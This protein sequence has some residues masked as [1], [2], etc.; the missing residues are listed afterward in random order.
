[1]SIPN[2]LIAA[3]GKHA[4]ISRLYLPGDPLRESP[5]RAQVDLIARGKFLALNY[6]WVFEGEPQA[7]LILIGLEH[8]GGPAGA[9]FVD[10]WHMGDKLMDCRGTETAKGLS[11]LGHYSV[12]GSPDWGWR[13]TVERDPGLRVAMYNVMPEGGEELGFELVY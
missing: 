11:V 3:V 5:S 7:G 8:E 9:G 10:S 6:E 13:I 12:E 2:P 4:G 1:M